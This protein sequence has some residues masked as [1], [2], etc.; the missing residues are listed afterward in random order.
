VVVEGIAQIKL[1]P[2]EVQAVAV[3]TAT[4][5]TLRQAALV[6][7]TKDMPVA[8]SQSMGLAQVAAALVLLVVMDRLF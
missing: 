8:P 7:L 2:P 1:A 3:A 5:L 6:Q 4:Q